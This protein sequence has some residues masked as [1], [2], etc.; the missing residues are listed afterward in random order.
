MGR[1]LP[2]SAQDN[3]SQLAK[4]DKTFSQAH[5]ILLHCIVG[6][7]ASKPVSYCMYSDSFINFA[8][9]EHGRRQAGTRCGTTSQSIWLVAGAD[10]RTCPAA[11]S[12]VPPS[13]QAAVRSRGTD[14]TVSRK[15]SR[16]VGDGSAIILAV[17][18][19]GC[20]AKQVPSL[21]GCQDPHR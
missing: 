4:P 15:A 12:S 3:H 17:L 18:S 10:P 16:W 7:G 9:S 11:S 6:L 13:S 5:S 14:I 20:R 19:L 21:S 1:H 2:D 8:G